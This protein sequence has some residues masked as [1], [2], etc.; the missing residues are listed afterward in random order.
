MMNADCILHAALEDDKE[1]AR[2]NNIFQNVKKINEERNTK[3]RLGYTATQC[4]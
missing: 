3:R 4:T 1:M 2:K